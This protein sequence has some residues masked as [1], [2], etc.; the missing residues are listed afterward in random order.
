[1]G[2]RPRN[3]GVADSVFHLDADWGTSL[4]YTLPLALS[5]AGRLA[6]I[7]MI[8]I[9]LIM[10]LVASGYKVICKHNPDGGGVYSS[11]KRVNRTLAVVGALLLITDYVVT[12]ALSISDAYHYLGLVN[13]IPAGIQHYAPTIWTVLIIMLLGFVNWFGPHFSAKFA[14]VASV[15]TYILA[16]ILA[17]LALPLVPAGLANIGKF[18]QD[19]FTVLRNTTGVLLAL[20]G[21]EAISNMTGIMKDPEKTSKKA[22]NIELMKVVF[23]TVVL[24]I[25]MNAMPSKLIYSY[26]TNS[27]GQEVIQTERVQQFDISCVYNTLTNSFQGKSYVCPITERNVSRDDM[28]VVMGEYLLPGQL[29]KV[30]GFIIGIAYGL[31]LIFAGNTAMIDITNVTY[32]LARDEELPGNYKILN[33]KHGV[34][35]WGL[36]TAVI[37]PIIIVLI[38]GANVSALAALYAIGVVSA[39]SLNLAGTALH[40]KGKD[41]IITAIGA[42]V[43]SILLVTLIL[44]K[45]EATIFASI[46]VSIG[47]FA[48]FI[49]KKYL[50]KKAKLS[51]VASSM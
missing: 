3:L 13:I 19:I 32:A 31:L 9:A 10:T 21:V 45:M 8:I 4:A 25:A 24:G 7:Y 34:P 46:V 28:L 29:G 17:L 26:E 15:A 47:L 14:G 30:Y 51:Q 6:P 2:H 22:M 27:N 16:G 40:V 44:V 33:K 23:T 37:V 38:V 43:M 18:N 11:L 20:S 1:L 42:I 39:V 36:I 41:R 35:I 12:Q 50:A 48:R 5:L 49:E